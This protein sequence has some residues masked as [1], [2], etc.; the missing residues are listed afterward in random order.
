[1]NTRTVL[2]LGLLASSACVDTG[3]ADDASG[4]DDA[5]T[6]DD[7]SD[8]DLNM[9]T[10]SSDLDAIV[11][12]HGDDRNHLPNNSFG[13]KANAGAPLVPRRREF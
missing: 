1:M 12:R 7:A 8:A 11:A 3:S 5:S 2:L 13:G 10:A 4:A 9:S 6:A